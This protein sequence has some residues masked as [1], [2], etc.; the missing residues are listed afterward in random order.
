[1]MRR[2][3]QEKTLHDL[4]DG[5]FKERRRPS[6]AGYDLHTIESSLI[7]LQIVLEIPEE[8]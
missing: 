3:F 1:M 4:N 2:A 5:I 8:A 7:K 6:V